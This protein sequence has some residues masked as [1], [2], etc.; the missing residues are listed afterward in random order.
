MLQGLAVHKESEAE[1]RMCEM[2]FQKH[3]MTKDTIYLLYHKAKLSFKT[4]F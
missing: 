2:T 3:E 1:K 4:L